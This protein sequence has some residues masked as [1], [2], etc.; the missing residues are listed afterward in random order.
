[1]IKIAIPKG[2]LLEDV[3][4]LFV[5]KNIISTEL[6]ETR[7]LITEKDGFRFLIVKPSDVATYVEQGVADL[8][9]V[10]LD[11][12]KEDPKDIYE[13]LDFKDIGKCKM[14][15]AGKP[16]KFDDYKMLHFTKV[17]TK[18]VNITKRFF[19]EKDVSIN[20]IKLNGSV[21]I[22]PIV[23]LSDYIVDITQTGKTLKENGLIVM[24]EIFE[25]Y[26]KAI[27][28]K[29]SFRIKKRDIFKIMSKLT[30][31]R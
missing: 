9:I 6:E 3:S 23:G 2:R 22:A 30:D 28:N 25:S 7:K 10:G 29:A 13:L 21:E 11:V 20:I 4:R 19:E 16:E 26:A 27:C 24:E 14:V 17:A 5:K 1:M 8:G 31:S 18:Y 12:L 15:V